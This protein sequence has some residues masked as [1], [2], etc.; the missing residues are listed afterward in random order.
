E[1]GHSAFV[2]G[3]LLM[4]VIIG[5]M[6]VSPITEPLSK[7][8]DGRWLVIPGFLLVAGGTF[9]L[10]HVSTESGWAFFLAPLAIAGAGFV[11]QE[12][13]T[14]GIRDRNV[15][16]EQFDDA[17]CICYTIFLL[18]VGLGV[19]V[20]SAVWQSQFA[21]NMKEFLSGADL[22]AGV[23]DKISV[24][25][26]DGGIS[27]DPASEISGPDTV[28]QLIQLTFAD[29]VNTALLSCVLIAFLGAFIGLF[30]TS[31]RKNDIDELNEER[32]NS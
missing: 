25:L 23:A 12:G 22:P 8:V 20:V 30:L 4:S 16:P 3:L 7:R 27:G 15:S 21:S 5:G 1:L 11:A 9:W 2:T 18:G 32:R 28:Q 19:A 29:A 6:F 26:F 24:I 13:P 10:A 31:N 14:M 17:W